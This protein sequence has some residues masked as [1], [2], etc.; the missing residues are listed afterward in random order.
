MM[1]YECFIYGSKALIFGLP[2]S[3]GMTFLIHMAMHNGIENDFFI[4]WNAV[5]VAIFSVFAV[6]FATMLYSMS[7]IKSDNLIET[8]KNENI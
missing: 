5:F 8:L 7:K 2:V 6:V 1:N 4:P 3:F